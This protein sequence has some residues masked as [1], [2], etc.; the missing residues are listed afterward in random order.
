MTLSAT[1][2]TLCALVAIKSRERCKSRLA[3]ALTEAERRSLVRSMLDNVLDAVHHARCVQRVVILSPERDEVPRHLAVLADKG[4][5]LNIA[6]TQ[7]QVQVRAWGH[8]ATIILPADLPQLRAPD[9]EAFVHAGQ[10]SGFAIAPDRLHRGTNALFLRTD[11]PFTFCFGPDSLRLHLKQAA[12]RGLST[13][14]VERPG[15]AFDI[16]EPADLQSLDLRA[17]A[18]RRDDNLREEAA[19]QTRIGL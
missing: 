19:W 15:L 17:L 5:S 13:R 18:A 1:S 10:Q 4:E 16:D 3:G 12:E 11:T 7:A 8:A 9:I 2:D 6:L 14:L